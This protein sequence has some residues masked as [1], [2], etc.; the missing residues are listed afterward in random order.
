MRPPSWVEVGV[1]AAIA[2]CAGSLAAISV[3]PD[4]RAPEPRSV[5]VDAAGARAAPAAGEV[6]TRAAYAVR[7]DTVLS[8]PGGVSHYAFVERPVGVH[9]R[10]GKHAPAIGALRTRTQDGTD[11]LVLVLRRRMTVAGRAWVKV[12]VPLLHR[13]PVG[14]IP[15]RALSRMV[16][17]RTLFVVD[18][19]AL[20]ARLYRGGR[21][22]LRVPVGIGAKVSPTP[23]GAFYVRDRFIGLDP[24]G[25]YGP[26]AFGTSARSRHLTDW[27]GGSFVGI[28]GTNQPQLIPGR[29]SHG[30]VRLR[31]RDIRRL[32]RL[33]PVG[34]PVTIR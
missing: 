14:W 22:V 20:R 19:A 4:E 21:V 13:P 15:Q 27:P 28:H 3:G 24:R 30:C 31:N 33:M 18:R 23:P 10:P 5:S 7:R 16:A 6:D 29:V 11:E 8:R 17:V 32:S 34:T 9:A 25:L 12:R 26:I 2:A 1:V